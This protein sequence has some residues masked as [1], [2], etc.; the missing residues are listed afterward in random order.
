MAKATAQYETIQRP[1]SATLELSI[2]EAEFLAAVMACVG[3][4]R[5]GIRKHAISIADTL[6]AVGITYHDT[7]A[8][9]ALSGTIVTGRITRG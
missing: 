3:G 4:D 5:A 1:T 6:G 2:D 7:E 9:K 8:N